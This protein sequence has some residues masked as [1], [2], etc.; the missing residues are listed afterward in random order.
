LRSGTAIIRARSLDRKD[1]GVPY[2]ERSRHDL[3]ATDGK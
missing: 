2:L 1:H 3:K